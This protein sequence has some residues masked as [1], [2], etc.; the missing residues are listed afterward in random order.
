MSVHTGF[1]LSSNME[2][3]VANGK[4]DIGVGKNILEKAR[5]VSF[6]YKFYL[7]T[8]IASNTIAN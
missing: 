2:S 5:N 1:F 4:V 7:I 8:N 3:L 6:V